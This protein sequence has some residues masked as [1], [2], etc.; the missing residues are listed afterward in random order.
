MK[1][2]TTLPWAEEIRRELHPAQL[3]WLKKT[4]S[5]VQPGSLILLNIH[6]PV[7]NRYKGAG[8][9]RNAAQLFEILKGYKYIYSPDI[10]ISTKTA[11]SLPIFMSITLVQ[12]AVPGQA[13][14]LNRG[15]PNGYLLVNVQGD[16]ISWQYKATERPLDYQFHVYRPGEFQ[17][18]PE[19]LVVN[20]WDYDPAWT[21]QYDEDGIEKK[22][23]LEAFDDEDQD[24]IT[25]KKGK[26][27]GYHTLH[28]SVYA[29][30]RTR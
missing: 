21:I 13:M 6:A 2:I 14:W 4:C 9:A 25:M 24:F 8:N 19:Y 20:L 27:T 18:Q 3:E 26:G 17:S 7:A 11:W 12:P 15:A 1:D 29:H 30:H 28:L 10:R 5:Y 16:D 23:A 22:G